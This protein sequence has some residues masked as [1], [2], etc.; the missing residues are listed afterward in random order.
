VGGVYL[1]SG[2]LIVPGDAPKDLIRAA[3]GIVIRSGAMRA[4]EVACIYRESR[5]DWTFPKG[6]ID[7]GET[8]E[9]AALREVHE[10]TG[11]R[12]RVIRF[13]G[14]TNYTHRK[15]RPKIV[16]YY[17]MEADR[18]EFAPNDEVDQLVW[19]TI[20]EVRGHLTWDRDQELFDLALDM[21]ELRAFA[22]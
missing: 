10:E 22:S 6:K 21:P 12:C 15:G 11:M 19:L 16:A 2:E 17:L 8:F 3:G 1:L 18:G 5:G 13:V 4:I 7:A 9:M 14:T 20:D